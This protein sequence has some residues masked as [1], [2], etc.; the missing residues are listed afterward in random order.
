MY[1]KIGELLEKLATKLGVTVDH[2]WA[3][4]VKQVRNQLIAEII[5][6]VVLL[7]ATIFFAIILKN[8]LKVARHEDWAWD[9]HEATMFCLIIGGF[10]LGVFWIALF[11]TLDSFLAMINNPEYVALKNVLG[12]ISSK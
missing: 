3:V 1:D 7:V 9:D 8:R 6:Y 2:L 10:I 12:I 5:G 11:A 4:L